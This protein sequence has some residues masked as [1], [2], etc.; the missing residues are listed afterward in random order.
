MTKEKWETLAGW[1]AEKIASL[2]QRRDEADTIIRESR[3]AIDRQMARADQLTGAILVL[4]EE[5]KISAQMESAPDA[6]EFGLKD[7]AALASEATR[8]KLADYAAE[9]AAESAE[10]AT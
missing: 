8:K 9:A 2:R 5:D 4:E 3:A 1:R 6:P 10:K 7:R